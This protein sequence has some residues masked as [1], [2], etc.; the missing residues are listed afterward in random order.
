VDS[1]ERAGFSSRA[2]TPITIDVSV[3]YRLR[4][5]FET[6]RRHHELLQRAEAM[7]SD[8]RREIRE[9]G[10][11]WLEVLQR[12]HRQLERMGGS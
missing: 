9:L 8:P 5:R 4:Q 2:G 11:R 6:R 3:D 10:D 7:R 1:L 12:A